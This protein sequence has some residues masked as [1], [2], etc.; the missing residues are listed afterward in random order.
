MYAAK[1]YGGLGNDARLQAEI[2]SSINIGVGVLSTNSYLKYILPI[3]TIDTINLIA[4]TL[5]VRKIFLE[6]NFENRKFRMILCFILV[7]R[8]S[9]GVN[10]A[11]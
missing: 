8:Y 5:Y 10:T 1:A 9:V 7:A 2:K 11:A 3:D 6:L 4:Y